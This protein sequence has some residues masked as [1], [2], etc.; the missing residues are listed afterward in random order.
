[1]K[2]VT[3]AQSQK[4]CEDLLVT[5]VSDRRVA[6]EQKKQVEADSERISIEAAE[7]KAIGD[8]A[9]ADLAVAMPALE[10]A[11]EEVD[12]LDKGSVSE[13]KAYK[14]PPALVET[15]MQ[16]VMILFGKPTDW[17]NAK[18]VLGQSNFLQQIKMFDKDNVSQSINNKIK[19][20]V[21][22]RV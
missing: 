21:D 14:T 20:F 5:I 11:M 19:K 1:M 15:V 17:A 3:V 8:D 2:K 6:D 12:K 4:S 10:K 18:T 13:V 7:C 9:E 22:M 16:A